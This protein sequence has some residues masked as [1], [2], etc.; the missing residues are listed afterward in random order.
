MV[1]PPVTETCRAH[2]SPLRCSKFA[3]AVTSHGKMYA[4]DKRPIHSHV[5]FSAKISAFGSNVARMTVNPPPPVKSV[6]PAG[7]ETNGTWSF[8]RS[9]EH[10]SELQSRV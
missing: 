10:T 4:P 7:L 5:L 9:E 1:R 3:E 2:G 8:V 6:R